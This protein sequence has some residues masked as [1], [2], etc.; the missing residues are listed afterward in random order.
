MAGNLLHTTLDE[1]EAARRKILH[2]AVVIISPLFVIAIVVCLLTNAEKGWV[3]FWAVIIAI[4]I[5]FI[6]VD[7]KLRNL[8]NDMRRALI[9]SWLRANNVK[10]RRNSRDCATQ[11]EFEFSGFMDEFPKTFSGL[12]NCNRLVNGIPVAASMLYVGVEGSP[13]YNSDGKTRRSERCR[14]SGLFLIAGERTQKTPIGS[15]VADVII[16][17]H[18]SLKLGELK[19]S[20]NSG[21]MIIS[22]TYV[23]Q[24]S[25][26]TAGMV[27]DDL[28]NHYYP[29]TWTYTRQ[30]L[31]QKDLHFS[32]SNGSS[33]F[34]VFVTS[35]RGEGNVTHQIQE[36]CLNI[37]REW[38]GLFRY[39]FQ[40]QG[41]I[42]FYRWQ[43][44][45]LN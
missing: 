31:E 26:Q 11:A 36:C 30:W 24:K 41:V 29:D 10:M 44:L 19:L 22:S 40:K 5:K 3:L 21:T 34:D 4:F 20:V 14:Y 28:T 23:K 8:K 25:I 13:V 32:D 2:N 16:A 38:G 43:P 33:E 37:A 1:L 39:R 17:S 12:E 15:I 18:K 7:T 6:V 45:P 9:D 42:C 35:E 27:K